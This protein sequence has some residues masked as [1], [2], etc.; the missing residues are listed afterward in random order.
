MLS[1]RDLL[2]YS[3]M[4]L[5]LYY[6]YVFDFTPL[7]YIMRFKLAVVVD[8]FECNARDEAPAA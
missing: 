2:L 4:D 1:R 8:H 5:D 3:F 6:G 7:R